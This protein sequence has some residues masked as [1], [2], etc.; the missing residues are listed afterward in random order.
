MDRLSGYLN[1]P[2]PKF[3]KFFPKGDVLYGFSVQWRQECC[4]ICIID[5]WLDSSPDALV[6]LRRMLEFHPDDRYCLYLRTISRGWILLY[7]YCSDAWISICWMVMHGRIT[8]EEALA[9]PY[10]KDFQGQMTEPITREHFNFDF[11]RRQDTSSADNGPLY[12]DTMSFEEV[13]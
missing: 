10:L 6:L 2:V 9:H 1:K 5:D 7:V 11:E 4:M 12:G 3:S 13:R 8:V